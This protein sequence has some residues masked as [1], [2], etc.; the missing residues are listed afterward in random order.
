MDNDDPRLTGLRRLIL[1]G[2]SVT[3]AGLPHLHGLTRL[4]LLRLGKH[5]SAAGARDLQ[6]RLPKTRIVHF[7]GGP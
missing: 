4:E 5:V 1:D 6:K 7:N 2:T 3:D